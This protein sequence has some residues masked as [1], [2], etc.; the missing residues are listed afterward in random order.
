MSESLQ[1][2]EI[3]AS[4]IKA[5]TVG[6]GTWAIGALK[7]LPLAQTTLTLALA[8]GCYAGAELVGGTWALP[9]NKAQWIRFAGKRRPARGWEAGRYRA[10]YSVTRQEAGRSLEIVNISREVELR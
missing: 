4:G 6:L 10:T 2:R 1:T 5:S 7:E 9:R 3:G 8:Y